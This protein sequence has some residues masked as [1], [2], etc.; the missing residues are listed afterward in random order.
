MVNTMIT[1]KGKEN[2]IKD[3][4]TIDLIEADFNFSNKILARL[5]INC[6]E[7]NGLILK[8]QYRSKKL[9]HVIH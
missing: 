1:K 9:H 2:A 4:C 5:I 8:E 3:P 6:A 7:M